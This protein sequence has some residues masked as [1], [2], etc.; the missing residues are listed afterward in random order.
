MCECQ[1]MTRE[2]AC[3][4]PL[5]RQG[6][7]HIF[8]RCLFPHCVRQCRCK[9]QETKNFIAMFHG[10]Q[11]PAGV[12]V[13]SNLLKHSIRNETFNTVAMLRKSPL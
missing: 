2:F 3:P 4:A 13:R 9:P 8:E 5:L 1:S 6:R 7:K 11:N 12:V 10:I